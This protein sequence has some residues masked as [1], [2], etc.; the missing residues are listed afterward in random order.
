MGIMVHKFYGFGKKFSS[1]DQGSHMDCLTTV[2]PAFAG[3][4][5]L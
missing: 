5:G 4:T 2:I 1:M 3:M